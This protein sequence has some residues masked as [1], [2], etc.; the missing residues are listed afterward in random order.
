[1]ISKFIIFY[2]LAILVF[3]GYFIYVIKIAKEQFVVKPLQFITD[4]QTI[5]L[6]TQN[7]YCYD[8]LSQI[9]M[10]KLLNSPFGGGLLLAVLP[11]NVK[12]W[13]TDTIRKTN[14]A[15][16]DEYSLSYNKTPE[17]LVSD[18]FDNDSNSQNE[19]VV[20]ELVKDQILDINKRLKNDS[21]KL[22]IL[23]G[24]IVTLKINN[25][26]YIGSN[27][28]NTFLF[29][30]TLPTSSSDGNYKWVI[31]IDKFYSDN[32]FDGK[33]VNFACVILE[34]YNPGSFLSLRLNT[35]CDY[36][37]YAEKLV[38]NL[39]TY[40]G[41]CI[42]L[43]SNTCTLDGINEAFKDIPLERSIKL[44]DCTECYHWQIRIKK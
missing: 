10:E 44:D 14:E 41:S 33:I 34:P 43:T 7:L 5:F 17:K 11:S 18:K 4:K 23:D 25:D 26:T 8:S 19:E 39:T 29:S 36:T 37:K 27:G 2:V 24:D 3:I 40:L 16:T 13:I 12:K 42:S 1:M 35:D 31:K 28:T 38:G 20:I 6:I 32:R 30:K 9:I 15:N 22:Y 21:G